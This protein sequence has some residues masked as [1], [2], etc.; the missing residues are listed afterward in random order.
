[1][2]S[3]QFGWCPPIAHGG[4]VSAGHDEEP[5]KSCLAG[6]LTANGLRLLA[7]SLDV[8]ETVEMEHRREVVFSMVLSS[9]AKCTPGRS[10]LLAYR[11]W[12]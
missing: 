1:M 11:H 4:H 7:Q 2:A 6:E 3:P 12:L 9:D 10:I 5:P 8:I